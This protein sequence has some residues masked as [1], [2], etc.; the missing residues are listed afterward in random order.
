MSIKICSH[1]NF[2]SKR[3]PKQGFS[4]F[5]GRFVEVH[6]YQCQNPDCNRTRL[7]F[8]DLTAKYLSKLFLPYLITLGLPILMIL[9]IVIFSSSQRPLEDIP[10]PSASLKNPINLKP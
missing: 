8:P 4:K 10:P 1:C 2:E 3:S 6:K 7:V 9:V 5:L